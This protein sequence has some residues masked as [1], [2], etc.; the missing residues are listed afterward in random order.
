MTS[1]STFV[2]GDILLEA[3]LPAGVVNILAGLGGDVGAPMV[4]HPL[5]EMVSF[6]GSTRVGKMTMAAASNSLK[7]V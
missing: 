1:A 2:L 4:S 6:T 3:G 5:V 7:K